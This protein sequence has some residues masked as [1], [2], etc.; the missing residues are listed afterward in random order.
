M[1]DDKIVVWFGGKR[2]FWCKLIV[3]INK[4]IDYCRKLYVGNVNII[5]YV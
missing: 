2:V 1:S 4:K 3:V 5:C